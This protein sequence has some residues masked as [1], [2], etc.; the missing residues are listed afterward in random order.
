MAN[1]DIKNIP[2]CVTH[3]VVNTFEVQFSMESKV[4][5]MSMA[6]ESIRG[7]EIDCLST[8]S[9]ESTNLLGTLAIGFP[10]HTLFKILEGMLGE[11]FT[12]LT[13]ENSDASGEI[14]NIIYGSARKVINEGGFDF[15]PAIPMTVLGT[16]LGLAKSHLVGTALFYE[17]ESS[18]GPFVVILSLK[19]KTP[20]TGQ[21]KN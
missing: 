21:I 3:S 13:P 1:P 8:L 9:L 7:I 15:K 11:T 5:G 20:N 2:P 10:R 19:A 6:L 17:C 4:R 16:G 12:E 18:A 14:L